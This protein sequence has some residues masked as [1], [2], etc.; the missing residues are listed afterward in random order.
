MG[1]ISSSDV[2][3][4]LGLAASH[5]RMIEAGSAILQP[6]RAVK[7]VQAFDTIEFV[8]LC[9]VLVSI[10]ILDS[11]KHSIDDM[12]T[13]LALLSEAN[14]PLSLVLKKFDPLWETISAGQ[15]SDVA[16]RIAAEGIINELESFL[17]TEPVSFTAEQMDN[18][19]TPTYQYPISGQLYSKI[20]DILQGV[21]PFYLDTILQLIDNLKG[22]TPRVTPDELAKWEANHK[23]RISHIIG[24]IRR[25]EVLLDVNVFDYGF[26][27]EENF[28]KM[29]IVYRDQP[30]GQAE[31]VHR[32]IAERL[33][34]RFDSERLRYERELKT[35][36]KILNEKLMIRHGKPSTSQIDEILLYRDVRMNNLWFYIMTSGYV[37]PF[38]DNARIDSEPG[39]LY[40]T[41]LAYNE[42]CEKL[43]NIRKIC[44]DLGFKV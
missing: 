11:A 25:P 21:A 20:G 14:P 26:L 28:E 39:S 37:V 15:S 42:T 33:R 23:G 41:S 35:F 16:R 40:G 36:H 5:Y 18:F 13:A 2:A 1:G 31:S 22:I 29:F 10:Q 7:V 3:A 12:R 6:A 34:K 4:S 43:V 27:W 30:K 8:P 19:M 44:S 38:I 32:Q 9:Q 17:T 24:V